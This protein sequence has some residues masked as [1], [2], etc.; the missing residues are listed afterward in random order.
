MPPSSKKRNLEESSDYDSSSEHH[1]SA[2]GIRTDAGLRRTAFAS[3]V[4]A[5]AP[6]AALA[7]S[8]SSSSRGRAGL[9]MKYRNEMA[10]VN[11][12]VYR[13][14]KRLLDSK[15]N[16]ISRDGFY[17]G[18]AET[19]LFQATEIRRRY[20]R[21]YGDIAVFGQGDCGQL[22]CGEGV[23]EA[24]KPRILLGLRGQEIT[25]VASGGLHSLALKDDG[26]VFSWGCNDEGS[27]GWKV[28]EAKDDG[29][30]PNLVE[31]FKPS[32]H[33]PNGKTKDTHD[34]FGKLIP[35]ES[36]KEAVITQIAAGETQ[37]AALSTEGDVY[38]WGAYKDNEG[39]TFRS[40]P[41]EDDTRL[42]TGNKD[43]DK[44][45]DDDN[46]EYYKP[47]RGTQDWPSHIVEITQKAK[48]ISCGASFSAALLE[49][50]TIVTMGVD[51]IGALARP[52]P[53]LSK[54]TPNEVVTSVFLKPQPPT[55][56]QPT[57]K[58]E[59]LQISCGG[60]HLL[61]VTREQDGL[62]VYSS[63]LN[64]Y[65]QLGHGDTENREVLTKVSA[66]E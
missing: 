54:K 9:E 46:P 57:M 49:D 5:P 26:S 40:M 63:G 39:R 21:K 38:V 14:A 51:D 45:E 62:G 32:V 56:E 10:A 30:L 31:G 42:N 47:P 18:I 24:R 4:A 3:T 16:D 11:Y 34:S 52:V 64:Q 37:S 29:A 36:R 17:S 8:T 59:V 53:K 48:D 55:W 50:G 13:L 65:G 44:L 27:L 28:T 7:T 35:F 43:M 61:A 19:Y 6:P 60:Y 58:R 23:T 20:H 41:P 2:K 66:N 12:Q 33:G 25:M 15:E 1:H 22:G